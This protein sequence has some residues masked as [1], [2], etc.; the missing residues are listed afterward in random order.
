MKILQELFRCHPKSPIKNFYFLTS[1]LNSKF[2][3][4]GQFENGELEGYG[5]LTQDSGV[6]EGNF[7]KGLKHGKGTIMA[8]FL[9][10]GEKK[11]Q[12]F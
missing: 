5:I 3:Y 4:D 7:K 11:G 8:G 9:R 1:L 6:Y 10:T 12:K 2:T